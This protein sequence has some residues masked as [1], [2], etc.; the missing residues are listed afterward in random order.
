MQNPQEITIM[1]TNDQSVYS[2]N[3]EWIDVVSEPIYSGVSQSRARPLVGFCCWL[4]V[5]AR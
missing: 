2:F 3:Y 1:T 5:V 4:V